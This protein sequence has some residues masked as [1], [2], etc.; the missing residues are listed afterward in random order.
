VDHYARRNRIGL[1]LQRDDG[2]IR[3]ARFT[4]AQ[5]RRDLAEAA[6][7]F[8]GQ[9]RTDR[10]EEPYLRRSLRHHYRPT[11]YLHKT[12]RTANHQ[13]HQEACRNSS[14]CSKV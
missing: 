9:D 13:Q 1:L 4:G 8:S 12:G 7:T 6:G 3:Q 11:Q 14:H 5:G 10:N 2:G